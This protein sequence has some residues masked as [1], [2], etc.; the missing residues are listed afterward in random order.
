MITKDKAPKP[1]TEKQAMADRERIN[2]LAVPKV[3]AIA[4]RLL[5]NGHVK[6]RYWQGQIHTAGMAPKNLSID[7]VD[8]SWR[9]F[10]NGRSG[11][12]VQSLIAYIAKLDSTTAQATLKNM[13]GVE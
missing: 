5:P 9:D 3:P 13:I 4:K 10:H 12:D 11:P 2:A 1:L 7:L 6:G 8:G